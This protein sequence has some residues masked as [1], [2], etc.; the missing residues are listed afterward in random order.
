MSA[1]PAISVIIPTLNRAEALRQVLDYFLVREPFRDFE[2]ILIDQSPQYNSEPE[3][4]A[5]GTGIPLR[6]V[7]ADFR[8]TTRARN[9]GVSMARAELIVFS[10]DDVEPWPGLLQAYWQF[11]QDPKHLAATGPVLLPGQRLRKREE[12][13]QADLQR[14]LDLRAMAFDLDFDFDAQFGAGGNSAYRR[15]VILQVG[16]FDEGFV[17][18][19]WGEEYEFGH[20]VR[21]RAGA[22]RYLPAAGVIHYTITEGGS[23]TAPRAEYIRDFVA[24]TI[25][26]TERTSID[27]AEYPMLLWHTLRRLVLNRANLLRLR[28]LG[29]G[30]AFLRGILAGLQAIRHNPRL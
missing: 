14:V 8:Q 4:L 2:L 7:H 28:L 30:C 1:Y 21:Q 10:E 16:G 3:R 13:R 22:I 18:N 19:A 15:S 9:L 24:N 26:A 12:L 25:Y 5:A 6:Y 20:R 17:G 23:R 29:P 27:P 11:F